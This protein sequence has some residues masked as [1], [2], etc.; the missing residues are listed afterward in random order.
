MGRGGRLVWAL[1][2]AL[3]G[4][5][6]LQHLTLAR[7]TSP[8][9]PSREAAAGYWVVSEIGA[10][11]G[12]GDAPRLGS[13]PVRLT[14]PV[15]GLAP[16]P[17]GRGY[18][19][20][21]ADGGIFSCGDS[22]FLGSTGAIRLNPPIVGMAA[23]PSGRGYWLV[24][25][26][27]GISSFG[28]ARFYGS[29]AEWASRV[30]GMA[31]L[32]PRRAQPEAP[33]MSPPRSDEASTTPTESTTTTGSATT[34]TS[35]TTSEPP[36]GAFQIGLMG[37]TG[38]NAEQQSQLLAVRAHMASFPLAFVVHDGDVD[39]PGGA[40]SDGALRS[41]M[42]VFNGFAAPFI[43]TPGDNEWQDCSDPRGRLAAIR[44]M[45]FAT[46]QS[47]GQRR[48]T[49]E[50]QPTYV[51]NARWSE[52][53]VYFATLNVP[54]PIGG[55]DATGEV[56]WLNETFDVA[57]AAGSRGVMI[58]WQDNPFD[59]T[60]NQTLVAT[61][62][63]RTI[64]F[65]RPVV[66]VHGD[67]H[68]YSLNRPWEDVANFTRLETYADLQADYWVRVTVD[69]RSANVFSFSTERAG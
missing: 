56:A 67:T 50:R 42:K 17:S 4:A 45:L 5:G 35:P 64:A 1:T 55:V 46:D 69:P 14:R 36:A 61:L 49:L 20:V 24:A 48:L 8:P 13:A 10:V 57:E 37:D 58:I 40:C 63:R 65:A 60:A 6:G 47:L 29:A 2:A 19:L 25:A 9:P 62:K 30:S 41:V 51:E 54:G 38:Y 33:A 3:L 15:V 28:D 59:G 26:D 12:F 18:W 44:R 66:L 11:Y 32:P 27:G 52:G 34:T 39:K 22:P 23:T 31:A 16:S 53:G 7:A 43:F 21:A 68:T